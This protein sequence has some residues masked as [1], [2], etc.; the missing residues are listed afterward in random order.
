MAVMQVLTK[1]VR[2][3]RTDLRVVWA[4]F[5]FK[6]NL[7]DREQHFANGVKRIH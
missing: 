3:R 2:S 4:D 6:M 1:R 7:C 5:N